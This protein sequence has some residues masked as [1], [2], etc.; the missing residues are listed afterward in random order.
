V[1][2]EV[3]LGRVHVAACSPIIMDDSVTPDCFELVDEVQ[4][5]QQEQ[6]YV[7]TYHIAAASRLLNLDLFTVQTALSLLGCRFWLQQESS[8]LAIPVEL[9]EL[10][11]VML[12]CS[13]W[14]ALIFRWDRPD[15][16]RW[17][18]RL[19]TSGLD[20]VVASSP[21]VTALAESL[22]KLF[23]D[24]DECYRKAIKQLDSKGFQEP[25]PEHVLQIATKFGAHVPAILLRA[26]ISI[27]TSRTSRS[28]PIERGAD[29]PK[30]KLSKQCLDS[31]EALGF[32]GFH[33]SSFVASV[34]RKGA[35][36][37]TMRGDRYALGGKQMKKLLPFIEGETRIQVDPLNEAFGQVDA[38]KVVS[39]CQLD[40]TSI[41]LL[42]MAAATLSVSDEDRVRHGTG[43][44]LEDVFAVRAGH[45]VRAPD[46]VAWPE[47][48]EEVE[49]ILRLAKS[50][51]WCIIP[52]GGG[53]NVSQATSCPSYE[54]EPRP[55]IS[56]DMR[57]MNRVKWVNEEDGVACIEAGITGRDLVEEMARLGFTIG[58][59]PD[60]FEFSTLGGWIA[61]K[62]SG[63]KRSKY[64]NIEDIVKGVRVAGSN[65]VLWHGRDETS[66]WG[67]ESCGI[68]LPALIIGSEGC[69]GI[70]TSAVVRIWPVPDVKDFDSVLL[71]DFEHG[72]HFVRDV[73]LL[74][75][76]SP[77]S[78]R[79]LDNEHF[80]L[81]QALQPDSDSWMVQ[82]QKSSMKSFVNWKFA[83]DPMRVVCVTIGYE[84]SK[85]EV[86]EQKRAMAR[87]C[88]MHG[89]IR[90]GP[91][92]GR[93]G[94]EMTFMIAYLRDFAMTYHFLGESF[95]TFAPWSKVE[96]IVH[97]TKECIIKEHTTRCLPG[98]PFVGCRVT[99]LYHEG[100]CLYFYLCMNF[101][102]VGS[103]S[104][105]FS[106][107]ERAARSEILLHGGSL[108]HHHGI[109]KVRSSFLDEINSPALQSAMKSVKQGMDPDNI[110][111][112]RNGAFASI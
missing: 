85:D 52:F 103:A 72:L 1:F 97:A 33:D 92:V 95:E 42:K 68:D 71:S 4:R 15:W 6:L 112:A 110:F 31:D 21:A 49:K 19:P 62:A 101:E 86:S 41:D 59:E 99:Q 28:K 22:G 16:S 35:A 14:L 10:C 96:A 75:R 94:Y 30:A 53:T 43:H 74:D 64:G 50:K 48:E 104:H 80:R 66:V 40:G 29:Q 63:M 37:V 65:G 102:K 73:F 100:V 7:S 34:D 89:G 111:A 25:K 9:S 67:R 107:I 32:W 51:H 77:S 20:P 13:P 54:V 36:F 61:T 45:P 11:G 81:G 26:S 58:H 3:N 108:S 79:L 69:L 56:V 55:I 38:Q 106:E 109:G 18:H 23:D 60:S 88:G 76:K 78:C 87:L 24:A 57:K 82:L 105:L 98:V 91:S 39:R 47:S 27:H 84:G 83:F 17:L 12:Q 8:T 5:R 90:L 46:V 93:A 2:G 44:A 70:I